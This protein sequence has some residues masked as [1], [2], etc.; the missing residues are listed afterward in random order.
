[1]SFSIK[2]KF[3]IIG[4]AHNNKEIKIK[5]RQDVKI[6]FLSSIFKRNKNYL[7]LY[8]FK[9]LTNLTKKKNIALGGVSNKNLKLL[10]LTNCIGFAGISFFQKKTAPIRGR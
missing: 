2:K 1:M 10:K 4:S 7:G 9:I 8:K 3:L 6:L 5:E